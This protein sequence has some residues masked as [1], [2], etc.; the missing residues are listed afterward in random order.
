MT[1][2]RTRVEALSAFGDITRLDH[3]ARLAE[4]HPDSP[5]GR[6]LIGLPPGARELVDRWRGVPLCAKADLLEDQESAPPFGGRLLVPVDEL[7]LVV[8]T[9]GSSGRRRENHCLS[10]SDEAAVLRMM[11]DALTGIGITANDVVALTLPIGTAGGGT[12]MY[13]ALRELGALCLRLGSSSTE[14][15]LHE[16]FDFGATVLIGTPSY[17]DRLGAAAAEMDLRLDRS[18][19]RL[20]LVA[21]QSLSEAWVRAVEAAWHARVHEWY[22]NAAGFFAMTCGIGVLSG[23]GRG[24]LHWDPAFQLLEVLDA[25]GQLVGGGD[26]GRLIGTHLSN[27]TAPLVRFQTGDAGRFVAPGECSCRSGRPGIEAGTIGRTD[28]MLKIRGV[29][30]FPAALEAT[31]FERPGHVV[32]YWVLAETGDGAREQAT[33]FVRPGMD[34]PNGFDAN[35]LGNRLRD[36]VGLRFNI[37]VWTDTGAPEPFGV[38]TTGKMRR[39]I[40]RRT[41]VA[42]GLAD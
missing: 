30:V 1:A 32:D 14:D 23:A 25:N 40:D 31:V 26:R 4:D 5:L 29:N 6:Q 18:Q 13:L 15:K 17:V 35:E 3:L 12:K 20:I 24:T 33:V 10:R 11:V 27:S 41:S 39:W 21:T 8:E 16:I 22:G 37:V 36:R 38:D 42:P 2:Q 19:V 28:M 34:G 9:S 7:S